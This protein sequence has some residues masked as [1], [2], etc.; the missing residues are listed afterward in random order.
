MTKIE[1]LYIKKWNKET[2]KI[3]WIKTNNLKLTFEGNNLPQEVRIFGGLTTIKVKL[4][5][6]EVQ[7]CYNCYAYRHL[8]FQCRSERK[9]LVC[10]SAFHGKCERVFLYQLQRK[11]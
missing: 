9:C 2:K 11:S 10:S 1:R 8:K 3:E 4:F 6:E 5:I 7:Q